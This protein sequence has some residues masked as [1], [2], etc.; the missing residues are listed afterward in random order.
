MLSVQ[1]NPQGHARWKTLH[2][3]IFAKDCTA[4]SATPAGIVTV[5]SPKGHILGQAFFSPHSQIML[6]RL[7]FSADLLTENFWRDRLQRAFQKRAALAETTTAYRVVF[8]ESDGLPSVVIDRY[9]DIAVIQTLSAG[10]ETIKDLLCHVV[11][12][13][14]PVNTLIERNDVAVRELEKLPLMKRVV[15]GAKTHTEIQDGPLRFEV[16]CL[17]GQKTG[18]FLDHR[19]SRRRLAQL[20]RGRVLDCFSYEGWGACYMAAQA[21][22]VIAVDISASA[23]ERIRANGVRNGAHNVQVQEADVFDFL[24]SCDD[25]GEKFDLIHLDPPAFIKNR[26]HLAA[27]IRGYKEINL[28]AL[29]CLNPGGTLVTSS[30]S[31]HLT[32]EVMREMLREAASDI[33]RELVVC[34]QIGQDEDHPV[35]LHFPESHYLKGFVLEAL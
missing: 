12:D 15:H 9:N 10:A 14:L 8:G 30:C 11:M 21:D 4:A 35:L 34:A 22:E 23:C 24:K 6:R 32:V 31:H 5:L 26:K 2:P 29:R 19:A 1:L 16:D 27:G 25:R 18:A 20:A 33:G 13:L 17:E 7:T 3:W 28:R